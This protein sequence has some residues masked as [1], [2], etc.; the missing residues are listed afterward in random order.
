MLRKIGDEG[1]HVFDSALGN[2]L[3]TGG[4]DRTRF[5]QARR[6]L[7]DNHQVVADSPRSGHAQLRLAP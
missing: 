7:I 6:Y 1:G 5:R 4:I 3:R 2:A